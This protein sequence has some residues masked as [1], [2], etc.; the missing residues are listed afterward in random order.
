MPAYDHYAE[1][2]KLRMS[3]FAAFIEVCEQDVIHLDTCLAEVTRLGMPFGIHFDRC[4]E[5]T[6]AR[7][8]AHPFLVAEHSQDDHSVEYTEMHKQGVISKIMLLNRFKWLVHWN[9]DEVWEKDTLQKLAKIADRDEH[10]LYCQWINCWG[11]V[12]HIR[13]DGPF[14]TPRVKLY[15]LSKGKWLANHAIIH[16]LKFLKTDG[17]I[18]ESENVVK[19]HVD[20]VCLHLG[21]MTRELREQHRERWDR[22]YN[23]ATR[24]D[25][26]PYGIWRMALDEE[27]Y[28][29]TVSENT[30]L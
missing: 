22:I 5:A 15:N 18:D 24:G 13:T 21:L 27:T 9:V 25:G 19:G 20:L 12:G 26:N 7:V 30:Y 14:N 11:D 28:P 2:R 16:G 10:Y 4:S 1:L 29:P 8:R 6:K 3:Q 17:Q 23:T